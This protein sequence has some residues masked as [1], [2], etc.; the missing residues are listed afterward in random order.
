VVP[1]FADQPF[2]GERVHAL[3]CG[4]KPIR[5]TKLSL[6]NL[7]SSLEK[8][9]TDPAY[10]RNAQKMGE[11]LQVEDGVGKAVRIIKE[12]LRHSSSIKSE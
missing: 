1:F 4:P 6:A 9:L 5:F 7:T 2:W 10:L 3:G 11:K 12:Y 8:L